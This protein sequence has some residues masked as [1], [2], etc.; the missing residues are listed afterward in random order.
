M[1]ANMRLPQTRC[2]A[3]DAGALRQAL[4]GMPDG[5][6][7]ML[8]LRAVGDLDFPV[9]GALVEGAR[10]VRARGG[11][12]EVSPLSPHARRVLNSTGL[13]KVL[14]ETSAT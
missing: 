14:T 5:V 13:A 4:R 8:D 1:I 12:V 3:Y 7:V 6:V 11:R 2:G 9:L 10:D